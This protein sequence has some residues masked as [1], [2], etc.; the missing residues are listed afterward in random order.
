VASSTSIADQVVRP[1]R[2]GIPERDLDDLRGRLE[3][4]RWSDEMI[5]AGSDYGVPAADVRRLVNYW[6]GRYNWRT[7]EARLNQYAPCETVIDGRR[8]H[9]LHVRS[10][11]PGAPGPSGWPDS[12]TTDMGPLVT[13][14][15]R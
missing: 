8:I 11:K 15:D 5:G 4:T 13:T 12:A 14:R 3:R 6:R 1:S 7:W 2:I 9:F 10:P